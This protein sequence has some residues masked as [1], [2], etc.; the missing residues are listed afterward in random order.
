MYIYNGENAEGLEE[1]VLLSKC[2]EECP[3]LYES[4][5]D[6]MCL[7]DSD[8]VIRGISP[9]VEQIL[10]YKSEKLIG[11]TIQEASILRQESMEETL[12]VLKDIFSSRRVSE[13]KIDLINKDGVEHSYII[14]SYPIVKDD[15]VDVAFLVVCKAITCRVSE[16]CLTCESCILHSII[17]NSANKIMVLNKNGRIIFISKRVREI[18]GLPKGDNAEICYNTSENYF[19]DL[20]GVPVPDEGM[21]FNRVMH[22]GK[23]V[24]DM[25]FVHNQANGRQVYFEV[26]G[27]PIMDESGEKEGVVLNFGDITEHQSIID[28]LLIRNDAIESSINAI[29]FAGLEGNINYVNRSFLKMWKYKRKEDVLGK[30]FFML[31]HNER[32]VKRVLDKLWE[33]GNWVGDMV[34]KRK[35]GS[36]FEVHFS[37]N[38]VKNRSDEPVSIMSSIEDIS[39]KV[40]MQNIINQSEKLSSL[41]QLAAGLSHELRN[42]LAVISSCAQLCLE[43]MDMP[44][45][46]KENIQIIY[47]NGMR[48]N[49]LINGLLEFARPS[50]MIWKPVNINEVVK[51]M[52]QMAKLEANSF[53][54]TVDIQFQKKLPEIT[55]DEGKLG[56]VFLNL[57]MNAFQA[58]STK[59]KITIQT[60]LLESKGLIEVNVIDD[61]CGIPDEFRQKVFEPFFTTKDYGTGL[62]LSIAHTIVE[63]HRG[64]ITFGLGQGGTKISVRLP[65]DN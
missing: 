60:L 48:A 23:A 32:E 57:F 33:Y 52:L 46:L 27:S 40:K 41:G 13:K 28:D 14:R 62:G 43:T 38:V 18:M 20:D 34:A 44:D 37:V 1:E 12:A 45:R 3:L 26:S 16:R 29:A 19:T 54:V 56:Q 24:Y 53:Q 5:T 6:F 9:S 30:S 59:G 49:E 17:N 4:V 63:Q 50:E 25:H 39:E 61:G 51:R 22:S 35:D 21:P 42:P 58:V 15:R 55:G 47:Q 65:T 64:S 11:K 31:W 7:V 2:K 8:C 36:L 10:G